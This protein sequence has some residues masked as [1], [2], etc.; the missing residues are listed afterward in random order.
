MAQR[1]TAVDLL[2]LSTLKWQHVN[3]YGT[4]TLKRLKRIPLE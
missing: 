2:A 3:T 4:F 1:R